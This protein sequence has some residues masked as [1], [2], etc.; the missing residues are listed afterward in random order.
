MHVRHE[1]STCVRVQTP[2][3]CRVPEHTLC[4]Q[5][6]CNVQVKISVVRDMY[7]IL[8]TMAIRER[9]SFGA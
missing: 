9:S 6:Y 2:K 1:I 8:I 7:I 3:A 5:Y 4:V